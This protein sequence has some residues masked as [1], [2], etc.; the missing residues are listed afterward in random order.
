MWFPPDQCTCSL[1]VITS[2]SVISSHAAES[3]TWF[4]ECFT[5][6]F[7]WLKVHYKPLSEEKHLHRLFLFLCLNKLNKQTILYNYIYI[8]F[9]D[10]VNKLTFKRTTHFHTV[11][12]CLYVAD[13][14]TFLASNS[15][16][17]L[18]FLWEQLVY[19]VMVKY[20]FLS[21]CCYLINIALHI[22]QLHTAPLMNERI[23]QLFLV[24][25]LLLLNNWLIKL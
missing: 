1:C 25:L 19:S 16:L 7:L 2:S 17:D 14:A 20:I 24:L 9:H 15:V 13:P 4:F 21:L 11:L 10:W 22:T 12:L 23:K 5:Q 18:L 3:L 8:I 6:K